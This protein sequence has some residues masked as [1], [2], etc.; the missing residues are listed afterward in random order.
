MDNDKWQAFVETR[1]SECLTMLSNL[2]LM[3]SLNDTVSNL[4]LMMS[5][6]DTVADDRPL[7]PQWGTPQW[8]TPADEPSPRLHRDDPDGLND[9]SACTSN[10]HNTFPNSDDTL[11]SCRYQFLAPVV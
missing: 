4:V 3:M 9:T 8:G 10:L 6:N 5:L 1:C 2:V 11:A 7:T